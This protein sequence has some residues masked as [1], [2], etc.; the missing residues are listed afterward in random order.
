MIPRR[1]I[2]LLPSPMMGSESRPVP[3]FAFP[4][5]DGQVDPRLVRQGNERDEDVIQ[6]RPN[7]EDTVHSTEVN[8]MNG[9]LSV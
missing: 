7:E 6:P 5:A 9:T 8:G 4:Y 3:F 1:R 2:R